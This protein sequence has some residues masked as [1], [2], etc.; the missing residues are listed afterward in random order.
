MLVLVIDDEPA[1]RQVLCAMLGRNGYDV[2][3][4]SNV[5]EAGARLAVGDV[6][7]ALCDIKMPD[8]NGIDLVRSTRAAGLDTPFLI[9]TAFASVETAVEALRAGA[10]DY[11]TK[12]VRGEEVLH[13]VAQLAAMR[14]L[15][16]ENRVLRRAVGDTP[17]QTSLSAIPVTISVGTAILQPDETV[18]TAAEIPVL[19]DFAFEHFA[20]RPQI[21]VKIVSGHCACAIVA[22]K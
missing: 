5:A 14:G 7:V 8:G 12:P 3:Q 4:A 22:V 16:E 10:S 11:I 2:D 21:L 9:M 19:G 15:R 6:D 20:G 17:V 13:R 1:I 18:D